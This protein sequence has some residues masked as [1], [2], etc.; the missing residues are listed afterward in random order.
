MANRNNHLLDAYQ[1]LK[2]QTEN[3][4]LET[5]IE[6]FGSTYQKPGARM[7]INKTGGMTGL[8]GGGCFERD[9]VEHAQ[10]VFENGSAKTV[11]Y[12][13]RSPDNF[14]WGLGLGCNGAVKVLLQLLKADD[15]FSPLDIIASSAEAN[16]SGVLVSLV[17]SSHSD[18]PSGQNIFL[19]A[20]TDDDHMLLSPEHFPFKTFALQAVIQ[21]QPHIES[22]VISGQLI[23][24]FY[25]PLQ[26]PSRLL[27]I[28]AGIDAIP[29]VTSAKA[30]GWRVTVIDHRTSYINQERFPLAERLLHLIPEDVNENLDLNQFNALVLMTHNIEYDERYLKAIV[31]CNIPYIGLLG[32]MQRKDRLMKSLGSHSAQIKERV[33]G[34]VGLDIGAETPEEIALSVMAG[35]YAELNRRSGLDLSQVDSTKLCE[36]SQR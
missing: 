6:T 12:D 14:V 36:C 25:D 31:N 9:L 2:L 13:M 22:H 17:E 10:S 28:G 11:F 7:L 33:F 5:I 29:L 18:F 15:G 21:K 4:V 34:P 16:L 8:L 35:I 24:A 20:S 1:Q 30:L 32:P 27:I 3:C 26:P 23:K 19:P